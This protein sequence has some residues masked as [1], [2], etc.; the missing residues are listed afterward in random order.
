ME[1]IQSVTVSGTATTTVEFTGIPQ[2]SNHLVAAFTARTTANSGS[3]RVRFI[4]DTGGDN[5]SL[6]GT[7]TTGGPQVSVMGA[8][9]SANFFST[10]YLFIPEYNESGIKSALFDFVQPNIGTDKIAHSTDNIAAFTSIQ[11]LMNGGDRFA[12][13]TRFSLY[14]ITAGT[15]GATFS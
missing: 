6:S 11:F 9:Q 8:S 2:D 15:G 10:G 13:A 14:K 12:P 1:L 4:S 5:V 3:M 7:E